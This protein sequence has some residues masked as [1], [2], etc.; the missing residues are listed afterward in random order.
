MSSTARGACRC[1]GVRF[2]LALPSKWVAHCHC[3]DCRRAHGAPF[4]TWA[5]FE[6]ARFSLDADSLQPTWYASSPGARRAFCPRCGSP[7][8]FES[9]RWPGEM[10]IARALIDGALDREPAAHVF[11][12]SRVPWLDVGDTLPKKV[13]ASAAS[14]PSPDT[15]HAAA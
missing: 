2:S 9:T 11:W 15:P 6:A 7:M 1:G 13:S 4:V 5:G 12:E 14:P 3:H 8:L 10:H